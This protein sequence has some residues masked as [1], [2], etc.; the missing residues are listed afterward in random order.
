MSSPSCGTQ[1]G[2][3]NWLKTSVKDAGSP[4]RIATS[5]RDAL[6]E[7]G[8]LLL[9]DSGGGDG[10]PGSLQRHARDPAESMEYLLAACVDVGPLQAVRDDA[11]QQ[12]G[13]VWRLHVP[14]KTRFDGVA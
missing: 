13:K 5:Q 9:R 7:K 8:L 1:L 10:E 3:D 4:A 12:N 6:L 2:F 14:T 11:R